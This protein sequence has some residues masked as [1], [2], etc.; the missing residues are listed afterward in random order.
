[1][2]QDTGHATMEILV[3]LAEGAA[4]DAVWLQHVEDCQ[5]CSAQVA[6]LRR[7][8]AIAGDAEL[9]EP[10]QGYW[11]KF[12][13]RLRKRL[14]DEGSQKGRARRWPWAVVAALAVMLM[15][16][17]AGDVVR[18]PR[19]VVPQSVETLLPPVGAD[20]E[21]QFILSVAELAGPD[22]E[23]ADELAGAPLAFLPYSPFDPAQLTPEE[24]QALLDELEQDLGAENDGKS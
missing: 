12:G 21:F 5:E 16:W 9:P 14:Q 24:Q 15:G 23:L 2:K 7:I 6:S 13:P 18:P 10:G 11:R 19:S 3:D 8:L 4:V 1:M 20:A 22:D 17:L